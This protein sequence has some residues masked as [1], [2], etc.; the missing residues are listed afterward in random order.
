M[1][2]APFLERFNAMVGRLRAHPEAEVYEVVVRPPASEQQL[3]DAEEI[4]GSRLPDDLRAFYLAHDGVFLEWGL[5]GREY[6]TL[7]DP[8]EF[9]DY[10][11]PPGCINLLPVGMAMTADWEENYH[12]N[13]IQDDHQALL[14]GARL[15]PQPDVKAVCIDNYSK[16]NHGDLIFGPE[17]VM[18]VSTD[19]G[20]DMNSSDFCSFSLYLEI[21]LASFGACRYSHG[22]G[23][24]WSRKSQRVTEWTRALELDALLAEL[25]ADDE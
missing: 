24:G 12:V 5:R 9:P 16:Y 11:Q 19:H 15:D 10:G 17:P 22:L 18:V 23:I 6:E 21:T 13:Q 1:H 2:T 20:A 8:F 7:T 3:R 14:F 25:R 4:V